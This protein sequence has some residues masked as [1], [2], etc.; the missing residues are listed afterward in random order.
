MLPQL[1]GGRN[2]CV[3]RPFPAPA[4]EARRDGTLRGQRRASGLRGNRRSADIYT[5]GMSRVAGPGVLAALLLWASG[6]ANLEPRERAAALAAGPPRAEGTLTQIQAR[7][8]EGGRY[9]IGRK[10]LVIRDRRF[11]MD[12]T[13]TVLAIYYYAGIELDGEFARYSGNGV[14]R[15][16][17]TLEA[18]RL[19]YRPVQPVTGDIVFWDNTYDRNG[20]G[21]W[22]DALTHVGMVL[23]AEED[24]TLEYVHLNYRKG[25]TV[26]YMN[27]GSPDV[28]QRLV[29][30]EMRIINSP[31]RML[32][33]GRPHPEKWLASQL[34]RVFA[35]G[36]LF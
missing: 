36:Y 26:E 18:H 9:V 16:Y 28:H 32:E 22:N 25:I 14:S 8:A 2:G 4:D 19:L 31:M 5:M 34:C 7:L 6:C 20:D 17:Q 21:E 30:G 3:A 29:K 12:C 1:K 13:G 27:L 23:A 35:M 33:A 10:E 11:A 15:L 24:G